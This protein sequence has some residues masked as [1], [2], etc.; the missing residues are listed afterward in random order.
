MD[1]QTAR[2]EA[3]FFASSPGQAISYQIGK[4]QIVKLLADAKTREGERFRLRR[5][6]DFLWTNGNVPIAL[7]RWEY[8]GDPSEIERL[9]SFQQ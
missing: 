3:A 9:D 6:H 5:F 4:I 1:R 8:L 2:E 7:L